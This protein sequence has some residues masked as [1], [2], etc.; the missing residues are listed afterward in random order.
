VGRGELST[1]EQDSEGEKEVRSDVKD[2]NVKDD[3]A[4]GSDNVDYYNA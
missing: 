3:N 4:S 1:P 2:D